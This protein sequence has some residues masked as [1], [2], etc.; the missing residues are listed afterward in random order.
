L[1]R[2][3]RLYL[4][5]ALF[6]NDALILKTLKSRQITLRNQV[7]G[8]GLRFRFDDFP[9]FG[10]W[11]AKDADFVCLEPWCG[12]ADVVGHNQQFTQKIGIVRLEPRGRWT[13]GW[14]VTCF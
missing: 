6:Y 7:T 14:T 3:H 4:E 8:Q 11:A 9:Y 2:N 1:L 13:R 5:Y 12:I 10:I